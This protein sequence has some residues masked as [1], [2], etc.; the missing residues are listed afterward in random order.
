MAN[1]MMITP[2]DVDAQNKGTWTE[3]QGV[4]LKICRSTNPGWRKKV[5]ELR[6]KGEAFQKVVSDMLSGVH[7]TE[8]DELVQFCE[9]MAETLLVDWKDHPS[10]EPYSKENATLLLTQDADCRFHVMAFA[11]EMSNFHKDR[12]T[13]TLGK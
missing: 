8:S 12:V 13:K 4:M 7:E 9:A 6:D 10:G 5:A 1:S 3:Y 11:G 2:V